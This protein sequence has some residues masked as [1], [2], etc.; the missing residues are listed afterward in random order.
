MA[1]SVAA[2]DE[3]LQ[4]FKKGNA[5]RA[6]QFFGD[7]SKSWLTDNNVV[8]WLE[9]CR[10]GMLH[11]KSKGLHSAVL[12]VHAFLQTGVLP[13][14]WWQKAHK[15]SPVKK[16]AAAAQA[17]LAAPKAAPKKA[18]PRKKA[19]S[20]AASTSAATAAAAESDVEMQEVEAA[21][22]PDVPAQ[23]AV[24]ATEAALPEAATESAQ[25]AAPQAV[26]G[27][28][29]TGAG[30]GAAAAAAHASAQPP[31][32]SNGGGSLGG[33]A[34]PAGSGSTSTRDMLR[35]VFNRI[36][37]LHP[38]AARLETPNSVV[39]LLAALRKHFGPAMALATEQLRG[40]DANDLLAALFS[41]AARRAIAPEDVERCFP[42][43]PHGKVL[44]PYALWDRIADLGE[45]G[46]CCS[47]CGSS[48][49]ERRNTCA[50]HLAGCWCCCSAANAASLCTRLSTC[51][52]LVELP[53]DQPTPAPPCQACTRCTGSCR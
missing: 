26:G 9:G 23:R 12:D 35:S 43:V 28:T 18:Q 51:A 2:R 52:A 3:Q 24:L 22:Q 29:P 19:P 10:K 5:H 40:K 4:S 27:A 44:M 31:A 7:T 42:L 6:V 13:L 48:S 37:L 1:P 34:R 30:D 46:C 17:E 39:D 21:A 14:G 50:A 53:A 38:A 25:V 41:W 15:L 16:A 36:K 45:P 47:S 49:Q 11:T 8:P 20:K 32:A 33:A